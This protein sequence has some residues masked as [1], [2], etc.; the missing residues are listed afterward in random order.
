LCSKFILLSKQSNKCKNFATAE[1][2][3]VCAGLVLNGFDEHID[4]DLIIRLI[5][6]QI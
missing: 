3:F 6:T 5:M 2:P 4:V 1:N